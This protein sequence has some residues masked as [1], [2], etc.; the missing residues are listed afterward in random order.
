VF[1]RQHSDNYN[2]I[3]RI[4]LFCV[5]V[6]HWFWKKLVALRYHT[7][8]WWRYTFWEPYTEPSQANE[9]LS[10]LC[11]YRIES[12]SRTKLKYCI[13]LIRHWKFGVLVF[14]VPENQRSKAWITCWIRWIQDPLELYLVRSAAKA[15]FTPQPV[16]KKSQLQP[17][18]ATGLETMSLEELNRLLNE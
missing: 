13:P 16:Q 1:T 9:S 7:W 8:L 10:D 14:F 11:G 2:D 18:I 12:S 4:D 17:K 5:D 15:V 6:L 3:R